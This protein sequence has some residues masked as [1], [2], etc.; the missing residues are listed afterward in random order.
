M[1]KI[2]LLL[3]VA[4]SLTSCLNGESGSDAH[5][6]ICKTV[7]KD[8]NTVKGIDVTVD[9]YNYSTEQTST[10]SEVNNSSDGVKFVFSDVRSDMRYIFTLT[11]VDLQSE[12]AYQTQRDTLYL[13]FVRGTEMS[14]T[15][16][17]LME[18]VAE[19]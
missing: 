8:N 18:P 15:L 6:F 2:V 10:F 9:A 7:D 16:N 17:F 1:K 4:F 11:D 12:G 5:L 14:L 19:E 3:A 13:N